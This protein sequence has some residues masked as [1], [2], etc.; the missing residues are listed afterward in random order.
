MNVTIEEISPVEKKL[1]VKVPWPR[2]QQKLDA[3]YRKLGREVTVRGFRKGKVPRPVLEQYFRHRV[4]QEVTG[5]LL[6]ESFFA[7]AEEHDLRPVAA[8]TI[9]DH[10][11]H[12]G[13]S[14]HY[15]ARVEV[16]SRVEPEGYEGLEV[17]R[18]RPRVTD[19]AVAEA[20]ERKRQELAQFRSIDPAV[21]SVTQAGDVLS[22]TVSGTILGGPTGDDPIKAQQV[23]VDLGQPESEP[24]PGLV[25]RLT[26]LPLG[27]KDL[28]IELDYRVD[29]GST[30]AIAIA[31]DSPHKPLI[32]RQ[33]HLTI[34][35]DDVRDKLV[36]ALDD[37]MAKDTGEADTLDELKQKLTRQLLERDEKASE[38]EGRAALIRALLAK[39]SF[40]VAASL[41]ERRLDGLVRNAKLS[42]YLRGVDPS[43]AAMDEGKLRDEMRQEATNQ[44]RT[45][46][47]LEAIG[48]KEKIEIV[49]ADVEK[50]LAERAAAMN[51]PPARL[52]AEYEQDERMDGL[53]RQLRDTK[54]LDLLL[55]KATV[56]WVD[57][58]DDAT[59]SPTGTK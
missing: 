22:V 37:E 30:S 42:L 29:G 4:E 57:A 28:A 17:E 19:K 3:A 58:S 38:Q 16:V 26:G 41:V 7:A 24:L 9:D 56:R 10:H 18:R 14:F 25:A 20:L 27:T 45:M 6:Q 50:E 1:D 13:E 40:P 35:L 59:A 33:A 23:Q 11:L 44:V 48:A 43:T 12:E 5:E 47:L 46:F 36:P 54:T 49:E 15:V 51:R 53:R 2:V 34:T 32:G 21:R 55:S 52:R 8:P 31:D 39:H